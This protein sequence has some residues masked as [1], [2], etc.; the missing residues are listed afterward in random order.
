MN[1]LLIILLVIVGIIALLLIIGL[2]SKKSYSIERQITINEPVNKVFNYIRY[3]KNQD[4]YSKWVMMDPNLKKAFSGIDGT[5]GFI[6][7]W[8]GN[9]RA[10]KGEQEIKLIDENKR[11]DM[12][13][14]FEKPFKGISQS[15]FTTTLLAPEKTNVSWG[16][17]STMKYPANILL[18]FMNMDKMLGRDME[19]SLAT[20]KSILEKM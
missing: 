18:L 5:V 10:G 6:Y 1:T 19:T 8:E 15:Y 13:V 3:L 11:I 7:A 16:F 17:S 12:E 9:K 14:R 20:L 2:V 4:N